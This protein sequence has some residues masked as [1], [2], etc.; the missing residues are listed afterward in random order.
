MNISIIGAGAWGTAVALSSLRAGHRVTLITKNQADADEINTFHENITFFPGIRVPSEIVVTHSYDSLASCDS[1]YLICPSA[2]IENVCT[3]IK[4]N[5]LN[6]KAVIFSFCKG[7]PGSTWELPSM[8]IKRHFPNIPFGVVSGPSYAKE[9]AL[10]LPT[11]LSLGSNDSQ[12]KNFPIS[13]SNMGI[14]FCDD[15]IGIE[16][17]G[18]LKNVYAIGAGMIDGLKL[19]D[20]AKSSYISIALQEIIS[21]GKQL[22]AKESTFFGPSGL[23]DLLATCSGTWSRNRSFGEKITENNDPQSIFNSSVSAIEGYRSAKTFHDIFQTK[24]IS[25]KL[26]ELIYQ[27]LYE[28]TPSKEEIKSKI[29]SNIFV[30]EQ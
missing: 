15:V 13:F 21:I 4:Q 2:A 23:G 3:N 30:P 26:L 6:P 25:T 7:L 16:L 24:N 10:D 20:N 27:I 19:G 17:G 29:L 9:V 1:L 11:K 14:E 8:F 5:K 22:G 12:L 28:K 18:C